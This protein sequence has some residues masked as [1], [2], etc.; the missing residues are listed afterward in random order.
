MNYP[1]K[2]YA[3]V[4]LLDVKIVNWKTG[5]SS[6]ENGKWVMYRQPY[7]VLEELDI[8]R[9]TTETFTKAVF[10]TNENN[11]FF[12]KTSKDFYKMFTLHE[13]FQDNMFK[14]Y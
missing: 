4:L 14:P 7:F 1:K 10:S 3:N 12:E 11:L 9:L 5:T 13:K 6:W 2:L 8:N